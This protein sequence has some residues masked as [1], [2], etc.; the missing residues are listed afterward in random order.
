[1][2]IA[3]LLPQATIDR[4]RFDVPLSGTQN[5]INRVFLLPE[6]FLPS[7]ISVYHNGRRLTVLIGNAGDFSIG[8]SAG[9][10]TGYDEIRFVSFKPKDSSVLRADYIL[11]E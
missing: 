9:L 8:E 1:M 11:D 4:F 5:G 3:Q 6:K 2:A 10:G 7:S